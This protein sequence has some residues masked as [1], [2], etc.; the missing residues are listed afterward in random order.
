MGGIDDPL[1]FDT[2]LHAYVLK[3]G[4]TAMGNY[5]FDELINLWEREKLTTEQAVGQV[6]L[7]LRSLSERIRDLERRLWKQE[8]ADGVPK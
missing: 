3:N 2:S 4:R 7:L 8:Q 6:L 1:L 5:N